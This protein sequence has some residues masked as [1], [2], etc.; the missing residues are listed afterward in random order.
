MDRLDTNL[1]LVMAPAIIH[2]GNVTATQGNVIAVDIT[3]EQ[4]VKVTS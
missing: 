3:M 2:L 4:L 1:V